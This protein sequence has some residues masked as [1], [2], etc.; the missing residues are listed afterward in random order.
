MSPGHAGAGWSGP[1]QKVYRPSAVRWLPPPRV[2]LRSAADP[3]A[4]YARP[5]GSIRFRRAG[6]AKALPAS[7]GRLQHNLIDIAPAPVL[8]RFERGHDGVLG[9]VKVLGCMLVF[10]RIAAAH[11]TAGPAKPQVDP[12]VS[13]LEAFLATSGLRFDIFHLAQM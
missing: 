1:G 11:V 13:H 6:P 9:R 4:R 5:S 12:C 7:L 2:R 8:T 10:G 3:S